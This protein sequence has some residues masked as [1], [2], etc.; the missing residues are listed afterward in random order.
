M[1]A[2]KKFILFFVY[3]TFILINAQAEGQRDRVP[4]DPAVRTGRLENGLTYYV[5]HNESPSDR[6]I[7][8][9]AVN[10]GSLMEDEDQLGM[11]HFLEHMAFNGTDEFAENELVRFLQGIGMQFGPDINAHTSFDETVYKLMIPLDQEGNLDTGLDI[12]E[13]WAFHMSLTGEDIEEERGI[14]HEEWRRGLGASRRMMDAAYPD[15][16]YKSLYGERLPIGTERSIL[17]STPDA[18][19]RF[20]RDW[21]RPDLMAVVAV[22]DFDPEDVE[23]R[24]I[25]R[26]SGYRNPPR[27]RERTEAE[28]PSHRETVYTNQSDPETTWTAAVI[29]NKFDSPEIRDREDYRDELMEDLY[30]TMFNNRLTDIQNSEDPPFSYAYVD[31]SDLTRDKRFH[32]MTVVT[33]EGELYR[34]YESILTEARRILDHGF[35]PGELERARKEFY[36][37]MFSIYNNRNRQESVELAEGYVDHYLDGKP[38]PG[39]DY[40][41]EVFNDYIETIGLDEIQ[42][43][44]DRWLGDANRVVYTM[45]PEN[46]ETDPIDPIRLSGINYRIGETPTEAPAEEKQ[47]S[48]L[49]SELPAE[50]EI[51]SRRRLEEADAEEWILSNGAKMVLKR[52]EFKENEILFS[53]MAPGGLSLAEDD[54]YISA[55]FA[56]ETVKQGG[57]GS[58]S[59]LDLDRVLAGSTV[60]LEPYLNDLAGGMRGDSSREDLETLLQLNYLSF[61]QPRLDMPVWNSFIRRYASQ[62][63]NRDSNPMTRYSD[64]LIE[65][66]YQDHLRSRPITADTLTQV[67]PEK[68]FSFYRERFSGAA[69]FTFFITGSYDEEETETLI[70]RYLASLPSGEKGEGWKDRGRRYPTGR[71][72]RSLESGR[73]PLSYVSLI[74]PGTWTWSPLETQVIQGIADALQM[75]VT[76]EIREKAAGTYS[77]SVSINA[78]KIPFENYFYMISFSCDPERTVELITL[79]DEILQNI[80]DKGIEER[81]IRDTIKARGVYLEE[82]QERNGFWKAR[83]ERRYLLDLPDEQV[84]ARNDLEGYFTVDMFQDR[85]RRYFN[86][87]NRMELILYPEKETEE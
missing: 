19:R 26:F 54:E 69:G 46:E 56:T 3:I 37:Y 27:S 66:L 9:L 36:A 45:S 57:V 18:I 80:K 53:A 71:I 10:A 60:S 74:Y 38:A 76:E 11:A 63:E 20:Y 73:E 43:K 35:T 55:S 44:A 72:S 79:V 14:I 81:F 39:M 32:N 68:A 6:A 77:P 24:I 59:K 5:R 8:R 2:L 47:V 21:Y 65:T 58:F 83:L 67:D 31:F 62:L 41:W 42:K 1:K 7:L 87:E 25:E 15:I 52:T 29:F 34:G 61:T 78:A 22:G 30:L 70:K 84:I 40:L 16:M 85:V 17:E 12:L 23:R 75:V 86:S 64:M 33:P 51:L 13:Q 50:G 48:S 4:L 49:M 82:Q 28:V